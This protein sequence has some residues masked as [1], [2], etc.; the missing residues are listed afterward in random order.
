MAAPGERAQH[1][2]RLR[3]VGG[4]A[5]QPGAEAD[6]RVDAED[7][8]AGHSRGHRGGLAERVLERDLVRRAVLQ[9]LDVGHLDLELDADLL[10]D[11]P[12][13]RRA[14][15]E[16][17]AAHADRQE[18]ARAQPRSGKNS[19]TSRAADSGESEPWTMF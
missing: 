2:P 5:V 9:L 6:E 7:E 1:R 17:H 4:L 8:R 13:L 16:H 15:G 12:P 3:F 18:Q 14:G 10:E 19:A 11:R